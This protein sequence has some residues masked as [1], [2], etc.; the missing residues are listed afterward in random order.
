MR[1]LASLKRDLSFP[2]VIPRAAR[3]LFA[4]AVGAALMFGFAGEARATAYASS[5][6]E[7]SG[8]TFTGPAFSSTIFTLQ[9]ISATLAGDTNKNATAGLKFSNSP[10]AS[11][12]QPLTCVDDS[13]ACATFSNNGYFASPDPTAPPGNYAVA[14]SDLND[15]TIRGANAPGHLGSKAVANLK[16]E[17]LGNAQ[18]GTKNSAEWNLTG[19]G[20]TNVRFTGSLQIDAQALADSLISTAQTTASLNVSIVQS[21][22]AD[23]VLFDLLLNPSTTACTNLSVAGP[24]GSDHP[25][26]DLVVAID[27]G[28]VPITG[29]TANVQKLRITFDT[30]ATVTQQALVPEPATLLLT[31]TGLLAVGLVVRR[32]FEKSS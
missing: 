9:P 23:I 8:M 26:D 32:R 12:D 7:L 21:G 5:I 31:G 28:L 3:P 24:S 25:C 18:T 4:V 20:A 22:L 30:N 19:H 17:S 15:T 16:G 29:A 11:L 1:K 2:E 27:S 13:G 10:G 6:L 14:D